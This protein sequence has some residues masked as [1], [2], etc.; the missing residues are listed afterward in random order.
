M[1]QEVD[2]YSISQHKEEKMISFKR[3][4]ELIENG[5]LEKRIGQARL[6]LFES[7]NIM[8]KKKL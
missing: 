2:K 5:K 4:V 8:L 3:F 1:R 7:R 6:K